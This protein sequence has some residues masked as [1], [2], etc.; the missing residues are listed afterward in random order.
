M[1]TKLLCFEWTNIF[2]QK[3]LELEKLDRISSLKF[4]LENLL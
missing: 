3:L 4:E 2:N 1:E